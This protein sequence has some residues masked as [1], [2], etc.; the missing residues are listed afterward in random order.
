VAQPL[1]ALPHITTNPRFVPRLVGLLRHPAFLVRIYA[2]LT[3]AG[4]NAREAVPDIIAVI[5]EP[6][7]FPDAATM[8]SGK[9]FDRSRIVRWRGYLCMALGRL[10]GAE[11]RK[12]LEAL[13]TDPDAYRDIRYGA[14]VGL[15]FLGSPWSITALE[16]VA[17]HDIIGAIREA[18]TE[19]AEE[20]RLQNRFAKLTGRSRRNDLSAEEE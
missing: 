9:H 18:A 16:R 17:A 1:A 14:V 10:G 4:L 8:T 19:A 2:A 3:L 7:P 20:I 11:A 12:A 15:R 6:Y 13:A 5:R